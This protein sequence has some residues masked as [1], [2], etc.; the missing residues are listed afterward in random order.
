M[1]LKLNERVIGIPALIVIVLGSMIVV[2]AI[3]HAM[4]HPL[5][6]KCGYFKLWH[7]GLVDAE[8]SQH[9]VDWYTPGHVVHGIVIYG[10]M[11]LF[12]QHRPSLRSGLIVT[13]LLASVWEII[14]NTPLVVHSFAL[15]T[16][17]A[18]YTGDSVISSIGDMLATM[19]GCAAAAYLPI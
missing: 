19:L 1:I 11:W 5:I 14:E 6:C 17:V 16:R 12:M 4:G 18:D 10:V 15:S 8:A 2:G 3:T 13:V 7:G 9:F